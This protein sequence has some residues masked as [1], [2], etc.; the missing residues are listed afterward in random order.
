MG[1]VERERREM[2]RL[3]VLAELAHVLLAVE[4]DADLRDQRDL[5]LEEVDMLL[6]VVHQL[7]EQVAGDVVAHAVAVRGGFFLERARGD[8]GPEITVQDRKST[9]LNSSHSQQSRMPSS[10]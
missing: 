1:D 4:F 7:L 9:R 8:F 6:L 10:A 3:L 5:R 2:P